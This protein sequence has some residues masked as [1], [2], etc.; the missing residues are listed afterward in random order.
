MCKDIEMVKQN[1][2][3]DEI[4]KDQTNSLNKTKIQVQIKT[5]Y[6]KIDES[7]HLARKLN[8]PITWQIYKVGLSNKT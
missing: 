1:V 2:R 8:A 3:K 6:L 5:P 4:Y 7:N